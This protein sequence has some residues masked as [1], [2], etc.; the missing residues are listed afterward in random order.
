MGGNRHTP[1][2]DKLT[3]NLATYVTDHIS[4]NMSVTQAATLCVNPRNTG[5]I[6]YVT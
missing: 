5:G 6:F 3:Q 4:F 1:V 2:A